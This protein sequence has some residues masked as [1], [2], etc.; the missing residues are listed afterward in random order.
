MLSTDL[1]NLELKRAIQYGLAIILN[2]IIIELN[3]FYY[4]RA[5]LIEIMYDTI[6]ISLHNLITDY[7]MKHIKERN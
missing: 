6:N 1:K 3:R 4:Y 2:L 5:Y 7:V